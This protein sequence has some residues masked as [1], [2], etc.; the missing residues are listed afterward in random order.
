M[1]APLTPP[2]ALAY[3]R[4]LSADIRAAIV[5]DAAGNRLAGPDPLAAPARA[6]LAEGPLVSALSGHGGAFG[7]RD[8]HHSVVAVTGPLALPRVVLHD[9]IRVLAALAP[10]RG[11]DDA[12]PAGDVRGEG[13]AGDAGAASR[14][15]DWDAPA[16]AGGLSRPA[17][18][19]LGGV[20]KPVSTPAAH[21]AAEAL[22]NAL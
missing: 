1:T 21:L 22:L 3:L 8:D 7:A 19:P 5:L 10:A 14:R 13:D 18:R 20:E 6:L 15:R 17:A 2:L 12:E 9:L 4:E 16:A 11:A